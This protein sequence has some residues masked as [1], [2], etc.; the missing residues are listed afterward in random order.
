MIRLYQKINHKGISVYTVPN[1]L[2]WRKELQGININGLHLTDV[3]SLVYSIRIDNAIQ[4][5]QEKGQEQMRKN[6]I[7]SITPAT[8]ED[9]D[10]L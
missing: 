4:Y 8:E 6:G 5:L 1:S 10:K 7:G 2:K 9:F 3:I